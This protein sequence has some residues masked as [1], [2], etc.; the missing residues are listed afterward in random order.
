M[1]PPQRPG[2][3]AGDPGVL[4]NIEAIFHEALALPEGDRPKLIEARCEGDTR[5]MAEVAS[6]LHACAEEELLSAAHLMGARNEGPG[7][8]QSRRVGAYQIDRLI[9]RGGM[10]AVY[11]AHRADGNFEQQVAV[12]LIDLP[13]ATD[14]FRE[15]FRLERQILAGLN[16]P[17]I[18]RLLDGGVTTE[19]EPFLVMEYVDGVPIHR[20]CENSDSPLPER[21]SLFRKVCAAVQ[22]AHQ[23]LVVH[24]DLKPDNI[25][26]TKDG[27]PRLLDFGTAKLLSP[28]TDRPDSELTRQGFQSFTPQYA[29][30]E[31]VLGHPITTASDTYSLGVLLY[32]LIT[33]TLPYEIKE[34]TTA[35]M[36]RVIC[37]EPPQRPT[38]DKGGRHLDPDLQAIL[39]KALRKEPGERYLTVAQLASDVQAYLEGRAVAARRGTLAYRAGK[40]A[41]RHR[42]A[43]V[44]ASL[45]LFS[46]L[47]GV[48]GV[49]WQASIAIAERRK[50]E[51]RAADLRELSNSLLSE[52]DEAI[53]ELPGS[54][55]VQH[56]LVTRVLE[57]LDRASKDAAGDRLTQ[58]DLV[59][60]YTRLGNIQGNPY[61]QNLGD[62]AG[63]LASLDKALAVANSLTKSWPNDH[64]SMRAM[65]SVLQSRSEI[66]WGMEKTPDAVTSMQAAVRIF[67]QLIA[68]PDA[69]PVLICDAGSAYGTLAD[70]LG[71]PGTPS[72]GDLAGALTVYR[73]VIQL[74]EKAIA[75]DSGF[76]RARRALV[77]NELKVGNVEI[78]TDP[79][80]ALNDYTAAAER[81][82]ALPEA[83][84][85]SLSSLRLRATLLRKR[86]TAMRELAQYAPAAPL[87]DQAL[88]IQRK[89]AAQDPKDSRSQFDVY[90][91]LTQ[92]SYD[93]EDAADPVFAAT[94]AERRR[95]L[96]MAVPLLKQAESIMVA[97]LKVNPAND[98]WRV[99]LA[100]ARVRLGTAQQELGKA[101]GSALAATGVAALKELAA[102]HQN[103]VF[104][105]DEYVAAL[106]QAEPVSLRNPQLAVAAEER[107]VLLTKRQDPAAL[108]WLAQAYQA[109]G[110]PERAH[111]AASEGLARLPQAPGFAAPRS[112]TGRLLES[113]MR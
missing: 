26:V 27:T 4:Q 100:D 97:L 20:F 49:L 33:G 25:L 19:G 34:F 16:H 13:L 28:S 105:L 107:E 70:E 3:V 43:L 40:F 91:D 10:G 22:F 14:L 111:A 42:I 95:N 103:T 66:L 76:L 17:W 99:A 37:E 51:A 87:F 65:A 59:N 47:A 68:A 56:L 53:K 8:G 63:A 36:V 62:P 109:A 2:P 60:A 58:L 77:V 64:Y 82:D 89:V 85:N 57:H 101:S 1:L 93:Y 5:L 9:G 71:Q 61:D 38:A 80:Q 67:D 83:K 29:S 112:R 46:V 104:V 48:G 45:L 78:E 12:K 18:A 55:G 74:D 32:L 113:E 102:K 41:R 92:A 7:D 84:Q 86:A 108:L 110:Q 69:T 81:F 35:E 73:K 75:M 24:R 52:L 106:L 88:A 31:Q 39:L 98:D 30:P 54:T 23:N 6:L 11:L 50:A 94:P 79:A 15:R 90:V 96:A 44:A 21:L 72:M